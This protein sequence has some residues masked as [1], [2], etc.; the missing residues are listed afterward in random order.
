MKLSMENNG[1]RIA[2]IL[3][4]YVKIAF[5]YLLASVNGD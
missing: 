4:V 3:Y 5:S 1:D 2:A